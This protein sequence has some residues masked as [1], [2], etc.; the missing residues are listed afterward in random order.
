MKTD[1]DGEGMNESS[2]VAAAGADVNRAKTLAREAV[3]TPSPGVPRSANP[4][5]LSM[6]RLTHYTPDSAAACLSAG[7]IVDHLLH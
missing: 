4:F 6:D 1:P 3:T 5:F 2:T 7:K